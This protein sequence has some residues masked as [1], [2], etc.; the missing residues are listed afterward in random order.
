MLEENKEK[1]E[2]LSKYLYEKETI[3]SEEF[4]S[5]LNDDKN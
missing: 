4:I 5:I 1:L 3:T 2:E